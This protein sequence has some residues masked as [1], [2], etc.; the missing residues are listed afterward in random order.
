MSVTDYEARFFELSRHVFMILPTD[1]ERV[2]RLTACL[3][4]GIQ[5]TIS[6]EVE[7]G[8]LYEQVVEIARWIEG[9]FQWVFGSQGQ[10][11]GQSSSAPRG[12]YECGELGHI[13]RSCPRFQGKAVEQGHQPMITALA[14]APA[15]RPARGSP[16]CVS[17]LVGDF[18]IVDRD[19]RSCIVTFYIYDTRADLLLLD[20][21]D[22]RPSW[23]WTGCLRI[24]PLMI[25]MPRLLP[26]QFQSYLSASSQVISF[27]KARH[28]VEKGCLAY[29]AYVR[30]TAA[31]TSMIDSVP[32]VRQF[33]D[34]LPSNL[35]GMPP[36]HDINRDRC[37]ELLK[38]Y[39]IT[40]LY[41]SGKANVVADA[42]SRKA[43][44][45]GSL[46]F[47]ST[48]ER[49]LAWD[50][51]SLANI[52]MREMVLWGGAKEVTIGKDGVLP[53][54]GP[55]CV[56]NVD[57]L[58]E[59]ILEEA[60][61]SRAER[62]G[63]PGRAQ[64]NLSSTDGQSER[65]V[66]ILEDMFRACMIDFGGKWDQF[67]PLAEFVYNNSYQYNI[68]MAPF[69]ALYGRRCRSPI[70]W[71]KPSEARLYG[72]DLLKEYVGEG[73]VDSKASSHSTIQTEEL[74][75]SEGA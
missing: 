10:T 17:T 3:H 39:D 65:I 9:F 16:V 28:M 54:Q 36:D 7:M 42:L 61:R 13:R 22:F 75:R 38:D 24:M 59:K 57:G 12:C 70:G 47:I 58:R 43:E 73:K 34:V 29:L 52:L 37:L 6:Q 35:P 33:S 14:T 11:Q 67:L 41:H 32:V 72:T 63:Y 18:V 46:A 31:G 69:E 48:E 74:R 40:I 20:M 66:Q 23:A 5:V 55:L 62:T 4:Y 49:P 19:Y 1:A 2:Q 30:V 27:L 60:H 53:L 56:P 44:S 64:H 26:W 21:T 68:E 25:A 45:M 8:T 71:F 50:I 15:V 51:Q